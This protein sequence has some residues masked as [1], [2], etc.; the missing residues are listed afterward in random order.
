MLSTFDSRS[1]LLD[2]QSLPLPNAA[3]KS[4]GAAGRVLAGPRKVGYLRLARLT[5]DAA[6]GVSE[7]LGHFARAGVVGIILD[8][9]GN[10]G[11]LFEQAGKIVDAFAKRGLIVSF[12]AK[13]GRRDTEARDD[14]TEP[15]V[16]VVVL[17]DHVTAAG[18]AIIAAGL[19][20]LAGAVLIGAATDV[21]TSVQS[22]YDI[23]SPLDVLHEGPPLAL[24]LT[25]GQ[26][27]LADGR[28][29]DGTG[30]V[31]DV[32]MDPRVLALEGPDASPELSPAITAARDALT[33]ASTSDR[34]AVIAAARAAVRSAE[35]HYTPKQASWLNPAE[36]EASLVSRECLGNRRIGH[37]HTLASQ[38]AAWRARA[39]KEG[40]P[41]RWNF[42][43]KDEFRST[44]PDPR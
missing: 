30:V 25:I 15:T 20:D 40:R 2:R 3:S 36:I 44:P 41:I 43:V 10:P 38:V 31:P 39:E 18:G 23:S 12:V 4:F 29:L 37:R 17:T 32:A 22:L 14:G 7:A 5:A 16:P 27:H 26:W 13:S 11:G 33:T 34:A 19:H 8:L 24:K 1:I 6:T 21:N 9:R 28:A 35:I 42:T